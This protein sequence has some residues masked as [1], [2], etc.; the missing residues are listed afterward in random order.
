MAAAV[1]GSTIQSARSTEADLAI[2][3]Y[4]TKNN[5]FKGTLKYRYSDFIVREVA[6]D[7]SVVKLTD[8]SSKI[9][10]GAQSEAA[11]ASEKPESETK[12]RMALLSEIVGAEQAG[13]VVELE[14]S[15]EGDAHGEPVVLN[16]DADKTRRTAVHQIVREHFPSM[17][18]DSV[19]V[20]DKNETAIRIFLKAGAVDGFDSGRPFKRQKKGSL[21]GSIFQARLCCV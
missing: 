19:K 15:G 6:M 8:T 5:G 7:G 18:S 14:K 20:G 13:K 1:E 9:K 2:T 11:P 3:E 10:I 17:S 12:D 21:D 16:P 4:A